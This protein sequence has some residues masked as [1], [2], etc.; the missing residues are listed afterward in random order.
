MEREL[1]LT[2]SPFGTL[3]QT[4]NE[5][6]KFAER[7]KRSI[8]KR[9]NKALFITSDPDCIEFTN[10]FSDV[11]YRTLKNSGIE[12]E[13]YKVL[14]GRNAGEA[15]E[16]VSESNFIILSGGHVPTQNM[17]FEKINLRELIKN[18]RG[19]VLGISA[20]TMNSADIVY[21]QPEEEGEGADPDYQK[22]LVGLNLTK[23]MV[24]PHY[25]NTKNHI[26]D[27][28]RLFED[29]T[30]PDSM[31][32]R[33]YA[34]PDGSYLYSAGGGELICGEA[35][36]I[37]DGVCRQICNDGEEIKPGANPD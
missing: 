3:G 29:I 10:E 26:L 24:I 19:T 31:G 25:Q 15:K 8:N 18:F 1:F 32:R 14:D 9:G 11:I 4:L 22:F 12:V 34:L 27:G 13:S 6:N 21:A 23:T 37:A 2:S 28:K 20:G 7:L 17:F 16:L 35:F 33:F 30:Y 36:L 5:Q